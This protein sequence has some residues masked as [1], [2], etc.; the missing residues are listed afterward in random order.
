MGRKRDLPRSHCPI[1]Y[2]LE[3]FG[4]PWTMLILR[5]LLLFGKRR[6][7]DFIRSEER[8][9]TNIL[10]DRLDRLTRNGLLLRTEKDPEYTATE[11]GIAL[12]PTLIEMSAWGAANDPKTASPPSFLKAYKKDREAVVKQ[13]QKNVRAGLAGYQPKEER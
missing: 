3:I 12:I 9:A 6:Y 1:N 10:S 4:D 2:G 8:I 13:I 7:R 5:D 11:K